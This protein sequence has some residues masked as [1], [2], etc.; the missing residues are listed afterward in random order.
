MV[1]QMLKPN[2]LWYTP[3]V[4][5]DAVKAFMPDYFDP[6]PIDPQ[7]DGLGLNE[8]GHEYWWPTDCFINPPYSRKLRRDFINQGNKQFGNDS[9]FLWLLNYGNNVD[10]ASLHKKASAVCIPYTRIRFV[11]GHQELG[12]GKS[13]MYDN[14]LILWGD[15]TGF[16]EAF[17]EIGK[18]Y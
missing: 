14:I 5:L 17:R 13:P 10:H 7:F 8:H 9:R 2:D 11:P 4:I 6:C 16:R 18:V 12:D 15:S 1:S 3:P